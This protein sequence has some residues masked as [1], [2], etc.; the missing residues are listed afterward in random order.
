MLPL[1][2]AVFVGFVAVDAPF[3][4]ILIFTAVRTTIKPDTLLGAVKT[5]PAW[6]THLGSELSRQRESIPK[7]LWRITLFYAKVVDCACHL[8]NVK[9]GIGLCKRYMT[10]EINRRIGKE[11]CRA[12]AV[13]SREDQNPM[14]LKQCPI[15]G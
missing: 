9:D 3:L 15:K 4:T 6:R 8:F 10:E 2:I 14:S 11:S 12:K 13:Y 5:C 7:G 1:L